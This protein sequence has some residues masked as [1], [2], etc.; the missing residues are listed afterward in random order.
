MSQAAFWKIGHGQIKD[1]CE[2]TIQKERKR[3]LK[4]RRWSII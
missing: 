2:V 1:W 4:R 3:N